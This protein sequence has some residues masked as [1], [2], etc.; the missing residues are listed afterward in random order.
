MLTQDMTESMD[1]LLEMR[2]ACGVL[3]NNVFFF[4]LPGST[5]RLRFYPVL[6]RVAVKE[7][8]FVDHNSDAEASSNPVAAPGMG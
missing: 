8:R 3:P 7:A 2:A 5:S 1:T 4:A 6:Q